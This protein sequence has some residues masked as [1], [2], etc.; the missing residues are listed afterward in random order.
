MGGRHAYLAAARYPEL[1]AAVSYYGFPC[2]GTDDSDT[3]IKLV[4]QMEVSTLGIF[5]KQDH[6]FP[7]SDVEEF[8]RV[9]LNKSKKNKV[10]IF[11]DVGHGFLNPYS[12]ARYGEKSATHAW[13]ET[14][15]FFKLNFDQK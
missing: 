7:F 12:E 3:P 9:L 5:G 8:E 11:E 14:I 2:Q 10:L 1:K 4:D 6:L 15:N 13:R